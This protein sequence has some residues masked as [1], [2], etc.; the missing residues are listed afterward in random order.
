MVLGIV[1]AQRKTS[2][3]H[4]GERRH[5]EK[6]PREVEITETTAEMTAETTGRRDRVRE[7]E[8]IGEEGGAGREKDGDVTGE[9]LA[10]TVIA[11]GAGRE[12]EIEVRVETESTRDGVSI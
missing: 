6:N 5:P 4:P 9:T 8:E 1:I 12:T 10:G 3:D 2:T 11:V 7:I